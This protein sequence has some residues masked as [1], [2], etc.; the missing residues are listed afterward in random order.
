MMALVTTKVLKF[1]MPLSP[2]VP[3]VPTATVLGLNVSVKYVLYEYDSDTLMPDSNFNAQSA[4][5]AVVPQDLP[6]THTRTL[7][8]FIN[9]RKL[10][11]HVRRDPVLMP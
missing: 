3:L 1:V 10:I 7:R 6:V 11:V 9:H 8:K 2:P 5:K 4:N